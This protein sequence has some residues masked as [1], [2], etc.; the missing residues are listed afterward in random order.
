M[1]L[2]WLLLDS[3]C[4]ALAYYEERLEGEYML[5]AML[6][7]HDAGVNKSLCGGINI[8]GVA[9]AEA[10]RLAVHTINKR[11]SLA[12]GPSPRVFGYDLKDTCNSKQGAMDIGYSFN[13]RVREQR[14]GKLGPKP[15]S[16]VV[17][18]FNRLEY[19]AVQL[20]SLERL[21]HISYT[22][23]NIKLVPMKEV[24]DNNFNHF[25]S[26]YPGDVY[27]VQAA[28]EMM[29]EMGIEYFTF[30]TS[31]DNRGTNGMNIIRKNYPGAAKFCYTEILAL[32]SKNSVIEIVSKIRRNPLAK[33]VLLHLNQGGSLRVFEEAKRQNLTNIIW[34]STVSWNSRIAD[35]SPFVSEVEGMVM[36]TNKPQKPSGYQL[37]LDRLELPY[38]EEPL[39]KYAFMK[40]TGEKECLSLSAN[41]SADV[42]N[43]CKKLHQ[44]FVGTLAKYSDR[45][46]YVLDSVFVFEEGINKMLDEGGRIKLIDAM[47][48]LE[49][50]SPMTQNPVRFDNNGVMLDIVSVIYNLQLNFATNK[51]EFIRVGEYDKNREISKRLNLNINVLRWKNGTKTAPV[52]KCSPDCLAGWKR[53]LPKTGPACCWKCQ[54]CPNG[55]ISENNN[56]VSCSKCGALFVNN[57]MQ[58]ACVK[59]RTT[60]F[61][62]FDPMGEFMI[63][64]ITAGLCATF[65][66]LG[67]FS[68]NRDCDV[69]KSADYK[70][71]VFM[72]FGLALC[73]FTPVPLLLE[74]SATTCISYVIMFNLGLTIPL[75]VLFIKSAAVR[76]RFFDENMELINGSL[77]SMPHLVIAGIIVS[78]QAIILGIGINL[79]DTDI[80][81]QETDQWDLKYS[82]CAYVKNAVF[83]VAFGYNVV[84]SVVL[85]VASFKST[86]M[87]GEFN[88]QKW[89][90]ISTCC[91]YLVSYLYV[92][93]L[94]A[95]YGANVVVA[96]S[97]LIVTFGLVFI[98]TYFAP[99]LRL[100]LFH[101]TPKA[102][103]GPDGKPLMSAEDKE[104]HTPALTSHMS[105]T[106]GLRKHKV[107]GMKIKSDMGSQGEP[108]SA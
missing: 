95:V 20:L 45:I 79:A 33:A 53:I 71:M 46:A 41:S 65:F 9:V 25:L 49:F 102:E 5:G 86:K 76:H 66:I 78:I 52:S 2:F 67:I 63:F 19:P 98:L 38:K 10:F 74:P 72:L 107:L 39:L 99:K 54:K 70:L 64:L 22:P 16:F 6:P 103:F 35:L 51:I 23:D 43:K 36:L 58:S 8:E 13:L 1:L 47:K 106:E 11:S 59:F 91:F 96:A 97:V 89:V 69:V 4:I 75:A 7:I 29:K 84:V 88:E 81:Y 61:G 83:W 55:S 68:Q 15:V 18:R 17:G 87:D 40:T 26:A 62:W 56:S 14:K 37:H 85:N 44:Q 48:A 31:N 32:E 82:Q 104:Q 101:Q 57:P 77:G 93:C 108:S 105:G 24:K 94:Y 34:F 50:L 100:I 80:E 21:P 73:F 92:T 30:I 3:F 28:V 90:C 12:S 42:L 27:K 60:S